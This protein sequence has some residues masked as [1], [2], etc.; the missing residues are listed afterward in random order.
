MISIFWGIL[1]YPIQR[2]IISSFW[3]IVLYIRNIILL[4]STTKKTLLIWIF[5]VYVLV[6]K[7]LQRICESVEGLVGI[8]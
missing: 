3:G 6:Y 7:N 8:I 4:V 5:R 1:W 2:K